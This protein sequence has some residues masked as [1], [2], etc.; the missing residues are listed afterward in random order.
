MNFI[1]ELTIKVG[2]TDIVNYLPKRGISAVQ[3]EIITGL[4]SPQKYI[5]PKYF[6]DQLGSELFEA[7][8]QLEEYYPTR[9]EKEILSSL[10]TQLDV[11]FHELDIVELGSGDASK[12]KTIF[13]QIPP[14]IL[15]SINYYPVDISQSALENSVQDIMEEFELNNITGIV[16]DF[17]HQHDY[18][19]RRN[20]R[21]FCFLGSTI[22]NFTPNEVENFIKE[23][24]EVMEEGD[25]LLLGVDM[26]KDR[27]VMESA[28]NDKKGITANFNKNVLTV[29]NSQIQS[30]FNT[31]DFDHL[32][33]YNQ[34]NRRIEMHLRAKSDLQITMGCTN[35]IIGIKKDETIHTENSCKFT[36]DKL[37]E[38]GKCGGLKIRQIFSDSKGW[39]SLVHFKH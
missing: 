10:V 35:E 5:S 3:D 19:P 15:A 21:L 9:C 39:F 34:V 26:V 12:I 24:G 32:A 37:E 8:T 36:V 31:D 38:I 20:K 18:A 28:Y 6:Y 11:N 23:L 33:F 1:D 14:E 29:I 2:K 27:V 16:A 17:L 4:K 30:N 7:I 22:G 13:K 25:A